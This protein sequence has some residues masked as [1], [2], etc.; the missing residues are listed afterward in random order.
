MHD[1]KID[2]RNSAQRF[3][4]LSCI[5]LS[6]TLGAAER[7]VPTTGTK[8]ERPSGG[9][10]GLALMRTSGITIDN[11]VLQDNY[12]LPSP[13]RRGSRANCRA[14]IPEN[15]RT[16]KSRRGAD[17]R[18]NPRRGADLIFPFLPPNPYIC[19]SRRCSLKIYTPKSSPPALPAGG[20]MKSGAPLPRRLPVAAGNRPRFRRDCDRAGRKQFPAAY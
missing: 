20:G 19:V 5:F 3:I 11:Y 13:C 10:S 1:R 8:A 15:L 14:C 4:F 2:L 12:V 6:F 17:L 16:R 18:R 9:C 7:M